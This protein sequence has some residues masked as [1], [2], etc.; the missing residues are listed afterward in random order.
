MAI[1]QITIIGT[2]LIGGSFGLALKKRRFPGRIVG[3]DRA[4]VLEQARNKGAI[5][6][7]H[8]DPASAVRGSQVVLLAAPVGAIVELIGRL[9][10]RASSEDSADRCRQ[11]QSRSSGPRD[12]YVRQGCWPPLSRRT[13]HGREGTVGSGRR[14]P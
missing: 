3:C 6:E 5:D 10:T 2:G 7:G 9:G 14:R 8:T 13:S 11:H 1:R 12:R 4:P